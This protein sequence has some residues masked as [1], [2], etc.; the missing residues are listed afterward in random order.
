M[1]AF[2]ERKVSMISLMTS[3]SD[4]KHKN[5]TPFY[6]HFGVVRLVPW[7]VHSAVIRKDRRDWELDL[8]PFTI[9]K[10]WHV[11]CMSPRALNCKTYENG[12]GLH[13][14]YRLSVHFDF[15]PYASN[16]PIMCSEVGSFLILWE[17][18]HSWGKKC[19]GILRAIYSDIL[20]NSPECLDHGQMNI[21]QSEATWSKAQPTV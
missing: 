20:V 14:H 11:R 8:S 17:F 1:N 6:L 21:T 9:I 19:G 4:W 5:V 13:S 7:T 15:L 12:A 10:L 2:V 3:W 16:D 18:M